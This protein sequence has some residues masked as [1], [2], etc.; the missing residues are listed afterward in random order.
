MPC[1]RYHVNSVTM[2][3]ETVFQ[4]SRDGAYCLEL[5]P[6]AFNAIIDQFHVTSNGPQRTQLIAAIANIIL[7]NRTL[8]AD[9]YVPNCAD[10]MME[11]LVLLMG[12]NDVSFALF[13]LVYLT[14]HHC[15]VRDYIQLNALLDSQLEAIDDTATKIE[16][17]KSLY[18]FYLRFPVDSGLNEYYLSLL[19]SDYALAKHTL[20][21]VGA[22]AEKVDL[23]P[24]I[25]SRIAQSAI[26][27]LKHCL[28]E[29]L[30][31]DLLVIL[32]LFNRL[33]TPVLDVVLPYQDA[34][35]Y[36]QLLLHVLLPITNEQQ[37]AATLILQ[38]LHLHTNTTAEFVELVGY[39]LAYT[40]LQANNIAVPPIELTK[41]LKPNLNYLSEENIKAFSQT[42]DVLDS[43]VSEN[44]Q[45]TNEMTQEEKE[46]EAEKLFVI[47]DRMEKLGTFQNFKNPI[48][49]WQ[50]LGKFEELN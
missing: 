19:G 41:H 38:L 39:T 27:T 48:R 43:F 5:V 10:K 1:Q 37:I 40:F 8:Y 28:E 49:D 25:Q 35:L 34:V 47:F 9:E 4:H 26:P 17:L 30:D 15:Q 2:E 23:A 33:N 12:E 42:S 14:L 50:Q 36:N 13:R 21:V 31:S 29:H 16:I 20:Q 44:Q 45:P 11:T 18:H 24:E 3:A 22:I 6:A 32:S 46:A 7:T